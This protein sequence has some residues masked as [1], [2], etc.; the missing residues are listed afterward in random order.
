MYCNLLITGL[1]SYNNKDD[2]LAILYPENLVQ[3]A[4]TCYRFK[5]YLLIK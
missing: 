2:N 3:M 1:S 4:S 5:K